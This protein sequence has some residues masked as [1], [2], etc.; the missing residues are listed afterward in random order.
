M[1]HKSNNMH[2]TNAVGIITPSMVLVNLVIP[3]LYIGLVIYAATSQRDQA[4]G[5]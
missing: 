1:I 4:P 3:D 5:Y 2:T